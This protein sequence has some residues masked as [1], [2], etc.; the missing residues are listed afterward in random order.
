MFIIGPL[1]LHALNHAQYVLI[2]VHGL[3][4][5]HGLNK[6]YPPF[7]N[8]GQYDS[9]AF[10]KNHCISSIPAIGVDLLFHIPEHPN[11]TPYVY[12]AIYQPISYA[13]RG[14]FGVPSYQ[15]TTDLTAPFGA[16]LNQGWKLVEINL[17]SSQMQRGEFVAPLPCIQGQARMHSNKVSW[18]VRKFLYHIQKRNYLWQFRC[19]EFRHL[20]R[21]LISRLKWA[22]N[23]LIAR[24]CRFGNHC[25]HKCQTAGM[26]DPDGTLLALSWLSLATRR[27]PSAIAKTTTSGDQKISGSLQSANQRP[28]KMSEL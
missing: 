23:F 11:P 2:L 13:V 15:C 28:R 3:D 12:Q 18:L 8:L 9:T 25:S 6:Y 17:D 14:G 7:L 26:F 27:M 5:T 16:Y 21:T 19:L 4:L 22:T 24:S 20:P 10:S 1:F